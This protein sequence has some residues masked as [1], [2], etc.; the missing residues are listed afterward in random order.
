[1]LRRL[2]IWTS[3]LCLSL[4]CIFL[5]SR[6]SSVCAR[7][8]RKKKLKYLYKIQKEDAKEEYGRKKNNRT[9]SGYMTVEEYEMLSA[10]KD[11]TQAEIP[12]PKPQKAADMKYIPHP[13]YEIVRYNNPPGSPEIY[14]GRN[15]KK[16]H[17][18]NAQGIVYPWIIKFLCILLF[19]IIPEEI[20]LHVICLLFPLILVE[21]LLLRLKKL[22][23]C[24]ETQIQ[25]C[26]L[27]NQLKIM[28]HL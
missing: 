25:Y 1:M 18:Q 26:Q 12:I 15:F 6:S 14:L 9:P 4:P 7:L 10:P 19:I 27:K 2:T 23:L 21:M 24:I 5:F 17:Q 8:I 22:M 11:K 16:T 3:V 13:D 20:Q 28:L